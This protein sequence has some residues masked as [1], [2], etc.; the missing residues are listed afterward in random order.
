[1]RTFSSLHTLVMA[2]ALLALAGCATHAPAGFADH[3]ASPTEH[4][5]AKVEEAPDQVAL[6]VHAD[7]LSTAQRTALAEFIARW[8]TAGSGAVVVRAPADAANPD[9]AR[10][11]AYAVQSHLQ[12]LGVPT[13]RIRLAAYQA[14]EP[15]GPILTSFV[16]MVAVGPDC[17]GGWDNLTSTNSNEPYSHFGCALTAD[18]AAQIADPRDLV[19]PPD[20]APGDNTRRTTVFG[21]Y[22][23]GKVTASE[24]DDQASGAVSTAVKQ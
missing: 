21:K 1:M 19:S 5:A 11:M 7:G 17:S 3:A 14:G 12:T 10:A 20:L 16:K 24:R 9:E 6:A 22:R 13:D 2:G 18:I 8:R 4:Y 23:D 15:K